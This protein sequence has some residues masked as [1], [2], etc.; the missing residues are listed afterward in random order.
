MESDRTPRQRQENENRRK[1]ER[2]KGIIYEF[3]DIV[4]KFTAFQKWGGSPQLRIAQY[5]I[6]KFIYPCLL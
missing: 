1:T 2:M 4:I 6:I 5:S 3:S